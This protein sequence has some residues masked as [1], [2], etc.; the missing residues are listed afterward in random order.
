[1]IRPDSGCTLAVMATT[2]RNRNASGSNPACLLG[3]YMYALCVSSATNTHGFCV[4]VFMRH[5]GYKFP[6][7][8]SFNL[9]L[10]ASPSS[11]F[12]IFLF[13]FACNILK[14]CF[15]SI[16]GF[17]TKSCKTSTVVSS[18]TILVVVIAVVKT[19]RLT[20]AVNEKKK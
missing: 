1:M 15:I 19:K 5:I 16:L 17:H 11:T 10:S 8:H 20:L 7:I 12:F 9:F 18:I 2:G 13:S 14:F 4:D 3:A 6:F